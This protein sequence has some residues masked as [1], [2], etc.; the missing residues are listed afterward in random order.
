MCLA[1]QMLFWALLL[2]SVLLKYCS[3][4]SPEHWCR[5]GVFFYERNLC[6]ETGADPGLVFKWGILRKNNFLTLF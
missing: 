1:L 2:G 6:Q 3:Q 5:A 4:E